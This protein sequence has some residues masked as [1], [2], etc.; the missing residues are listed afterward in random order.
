MHNQVKKQ[1]Q[2]IHSETTR[3]QDLRCLFF[4]PF[5][6]GLTGEKLEPKKFLLNLLGAG[7]KS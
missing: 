4:S 3:S 5:S 7:N 6:D 2:A 1:L